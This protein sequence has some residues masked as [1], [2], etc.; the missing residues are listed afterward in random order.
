MGHSECGAV[1][2]AL[3]KQK[4]PGALGKLID[5][6]QIGEVPSDKSALSVAIRNNVDLAIVQFRK[7]SPNLNE[8]IRQD[9][10]RLVGAVY[11]LE[12]GQ[13]EWLPAKK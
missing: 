4:I 9:R 13:V 7:V 11:S 1:K 10:I 3:S 5:Q 12:T 8:M 6:V 2:A